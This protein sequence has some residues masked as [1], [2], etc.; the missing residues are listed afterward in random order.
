[1]TRADGAAVA[2]SK[3]EQVVLGKLRPGPGLARETVAAD[4]R[5]RLRAALSGLAAESGYDTVT[6]RALIHRASVSTST[7]YKHFGGVE[8]CFA[9]IVGMTIRGLVARM[10]AARGPDADVLAGLRAAVRYLMESMAREPETAR[11]VL[12]EAFAAGPR[13]RAEMEAALGELEQLLAESLAVAPRP[14]VG[15]PHLAVGLIAGA[16][17][18]VRKTALTGRADELPGLADELTDWMLAIAHEEVVTFR[19]PHSRPP[20]ESADAVPV[21]IGPPLSSRELFSDSGRRA[22]MA[23]ARIAAA[24]GLAGLTSARI[25]KDAGLSREEFDAHFKGVED[26]FLATVVSIGEMAAE[27]A[28][29]AAQ[30]AGTWERRIYRTM[31]A[32]CTLAAA[33]RALSRMVLVEITAPGRTGLL[34]REELIGRCA[35]HLRHAAPTDRRPSVLA[36]DASVSAIWRIAET[37]V[38]AGRAAQLP[39]VAPVFVYMLLA[40]RRPRAAA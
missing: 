31:T 16:A 26:C 36:A 10:A 9:A 18:I 11:A 33:D 21:R 6:V 34:R 19:S 29:L 14:A 27:T 32:L 13:V 30:D 4:Q 23:T 28:E 5:L 17:R 37:E 39:L 12:V 8:E 15:T 22:V 25:R 38:A 1:M 7:F 24:N 40:S 2:A 35:D 20:H 3:P